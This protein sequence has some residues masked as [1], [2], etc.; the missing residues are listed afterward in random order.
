MYQVHEKIHTSEDQ[1]RPVQGACET[2][3]YKYYRELTNSLESECH[4]RNA[5]T[6]NIGLGSTYHFYIQK[7]EKLIF[8]GTQL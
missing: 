8:N 3:I 1:T 2:R 6:V 7:K 5:I 4:Y